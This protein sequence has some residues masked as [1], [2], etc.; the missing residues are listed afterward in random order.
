MW[1]AW[2]PRFP[3]AYLDSV[4]DGKREGEG[5]IRVEGN[6]VVSTVGAGNMALQ[7]A[8]AVVHHNTVIPLDMIPP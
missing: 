8:L 3:H 4:H 7:E 6:G 2:T 1:E 5:E